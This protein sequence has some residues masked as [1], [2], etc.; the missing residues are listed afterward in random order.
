MASIVGNVSKGTCETCG[1]GPGQRHKATE[2]RP[3]FEQLEAWVSDGV[4]EA[5]DGCTVEPDGECSHGHRSWLLV[6]GYI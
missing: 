3:T 5:T 2:P 4:A 1:A 6:L